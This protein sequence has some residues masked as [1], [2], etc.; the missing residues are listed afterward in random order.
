MKENIIGAVA[1]VA[2]IL[3]GWMAYQNMSLH[4]NGF[5][6]TAAGNLLAE[7]YIPYVLYN[8]G[9]NSAKDVSTTGGLYG[10]TLTTTG[11]SVFGSTVTVTTSNSAT[12]TVSLGCIQTTATS[13]ATPVRLVIGSSG[14]TTSYQGSV[15]TGV[16]GW[17]YGSCPI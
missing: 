16:V 4:S 14:A 2:L 1:L 13:T 6:A 7:N 10:A 12:S 17:Q 3:A 5:G 8:G 15:A 9:Y 11:A